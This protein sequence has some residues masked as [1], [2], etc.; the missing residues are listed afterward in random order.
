MSSLPVRTVNLLNDLDGRFPEVVIDAVIDLYREGLMQPVVN[1]VEGLYDRF[2]SIRELRL[3]RSEAW[4]LYLRLVFDCVIEPEWVHYTFAFRACLL[5]FVT[6]LALDSQ[7]PRSV[8]R[9]FELG[10]VPEDEE[11]RRRLHLG[12]LWSSNFLDEDF[13]EDPDEL[14]PH[15]EEISLNPPYV[16]FGS[17]QRPSLRNGRLMMCFPV[18]LQEK[19]GQRKWR[20]RRRPAGPRHSNQIVSDTI[21]FHRAP[22]PVLH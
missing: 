14:C 7:A 15:G 18:E 12:N 2:A 10:T 3:R 11:A 9:W 19:Q 1:A 17:L 4:I 5:V 16:G 6:R 13:E 22:Q 20:E 21:I 8:R